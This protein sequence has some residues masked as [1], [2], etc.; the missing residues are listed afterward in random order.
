MALARGVFTQSVHTTSHLLPHMTCTMST[1]TSVNEAKQAK[2]KLP[3]AS[4]IYAKTNKKDFKLET[5]ICVSH[6][7]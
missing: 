4:V 3:Y 7:I 2:E 6:F 1:G 5:L